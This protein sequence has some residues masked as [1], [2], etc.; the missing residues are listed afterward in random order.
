MSVWIVVLG[1]PVGVQAEEED[2][3]CEV[4][5]GNLRSARAFAADAQ[6]RFQY[7]VG[8]HPVQPHRSAQAAREWYERAIGVWPERPRTRHVFPDRYKPDGSG[9]RWCSAHEHW[10]EP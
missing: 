4:R 6:G 8:P 7:V 2:E 1:T 9:Q 5:F 10:V 3:P